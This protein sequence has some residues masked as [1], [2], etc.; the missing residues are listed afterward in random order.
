[1]RQKGIYM[2]RNKVD[3]KVYIGQFID[4]SNLVKCCKGKTK[5]C[6]KL[7]GTPMYWKYY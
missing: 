7:D 2:I 6:G 4:M 5:Y 3:N 1:M